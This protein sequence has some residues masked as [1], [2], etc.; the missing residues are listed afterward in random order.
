MSSAS[1]EEDNLRRGEERDETRAVWGGAAVIFGLL[2]E[3]AYA[4]AYSKGQSIVEEWGPVFADAFVALGVAT[5]VLYAARARSKAAAIKR[6]SDEKIAAANE[7]AAEAL[8]KAEE[9]SHARV[10][11]EMN[12]QPRSV[13]PEQFHFIQGLGGRLEGINIGYESDGETLWFARQLE[14]AFL[15]AGIAVSMFQRPAEVHSFAILIYEPNG[16]DGSRAR[17]VEPLV[18]IFRMSEIRPA[19]AVITGMPT[20]IQAPTNIPMIIVGGR[21][22]LQPTLFPDLSRA[23]S[24]PST[25]AEG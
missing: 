5:E 15:R 10:K 22:V 25:S 2:L 11:L 16:F 1:D 21:F 18:D 17:T 8:Q 14:G 4:I 13:S 7:R 24:F 23:K 19:L 9:E 3:V 12:L 20:D 6:R